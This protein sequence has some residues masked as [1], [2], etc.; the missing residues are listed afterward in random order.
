MNETAE[1]TQ[2]GHAQSQEFCPESRSNSG[3]KGPRKSRRTSATSTKEGRIPLDA[4]DSAQGLTDILLN[5]PD[6]NIRG[7]VIE[8]CAGSGAISNRLWE[9]HLQH[10]RGSRII[11]CD[12]VPRIAPCHVWDATKQEDW[13]A[14]IAL[15]TPGAPT[16]PDWAITN[17]PFNLAYQ[18]LPLALQFCPNVAFLLRLSY[19]E[20]TKNRFNWL[21]ANADQMVALI[22]I[23][24]RPQFRL[25][26]HGELDSDSVTVAWYVWSANWSWRKLGILPPFRF[27]GEWN[28]P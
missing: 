17:P 5:Q 14:L 26:S 1:Q 4:Y 23:S 20:P 13:E 9:K 16:K 6:L 22:P 15:D 12:I 3:D 11:P 2:N 18:I 10:Q 28:R 8:P 24:P 7:V 21:N 25:N 19:L 27:A